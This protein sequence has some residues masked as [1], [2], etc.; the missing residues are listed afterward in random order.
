MLREHQRTL[1]YRTS[2]GPRAP[3]ERGPDRFSKKRAPRFG[4]SSTSASAMQKGALYMKEGVGPL[5]R[6]VG[7]RVTMPAALLLVSDPSPRAAV[8][9]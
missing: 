4:W 9:Q 6:A 7:K 1:L 8:A 3:R 5:G 2:R